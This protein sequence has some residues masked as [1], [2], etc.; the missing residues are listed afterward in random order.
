[1]YNMIRPVNTVTNDVAKELQRV[2]RDNSIP[3]S[4]LYIEI[5]SVNTF[6]SDGDSGFTEMSNDE[7]NKYKYKKI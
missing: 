6:V 2:A 1:M 5:D 4:K 7:F 3:I